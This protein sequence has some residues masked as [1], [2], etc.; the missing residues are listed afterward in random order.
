MFNIFA[1]SIR[2]ATRLNSWDAPDHWRRQHQDY[3]NRRCGQ[4]DRAARLRATL[5][6]TGLR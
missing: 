6:E 5:E 4:C 2:N 1:R 3:L